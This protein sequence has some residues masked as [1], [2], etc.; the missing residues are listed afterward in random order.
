MVHG[1]GSTG[2]FDVL[3]AVA[4]ASEN[5]RGSPAKA[6]LGLGHGFDLREDH[7]VEGL[8]IHVLEPELRPSPQV[9]GMRPPCGKRLQGLP[10]GHFHHRHVVAVEGE[11][12]LESVIFGVS[13]HG[14][15][16]W[17]GRW[18]SNPQELQV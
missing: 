18:D 8:G 13:G 10:T 17:C 7:G 16:H 1:G 6:K 12:R 11:N 2:A 4:I 5:A 9:Q 14:K 15:P 3:T